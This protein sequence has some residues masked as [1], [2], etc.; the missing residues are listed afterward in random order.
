[1]D[2]EV[3]IMGSDANA[4][5]MARCCHEAYHKKA[6]L[7]GAYYRA[8]T[9]YSNILTIE[10]DPEIWSEEGFL[11]AL[12]NFRS[13]YPKSKILLIASNETYAEFIS[14]NRDTLKKDF[15]FNYPSIDI[16]KSLTTKEIFYKTYE[17]SILDFPK[18]KYYD[19]SSEDTLD[20]DFTY[21][22]IVK[23]SNVVS[24][25]HI[26][27]EGKNKIYKVEDK[28]ELKDIVDRIKMGGYQDT[29]IIQEFIPGDDSHLFDAVVYADRNKKVK[30]VSFAQIGLQ[31]H[32]KRMVGN[33]AVLMNGYNTFDGN[34]EEMVENI[35]TF[36]ENIGYMGFAEFDMKY[37]ERDHKFKVLEI[38]ARQGRCSYYISAAGFN[39]VSTMVDDLILEREIPYHVIQEPVLLSFVPKK[40]AKD[41]IKNEQLK[42]DVLKKWHQHV[43]PMKYKKD[44]NLRRKV[45]LWK[46]NK[47]YV[48]E[49][50]NGYWK[51]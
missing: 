34:V 37:D 12:K 46:M 27:F 26:D 22:I 6:H 14:K 17:N 49:Y 8:F 51:D 36:M 10:Y 19:C 39:L 48:E 45:L 35:K 42:K 3:L 25:N 4:Y 47:R 32:A 50:K 29:L 9:K 20:I 5:Y 23:P 2:F 41:Y 1:M 18:T 31:E 13:R 24:Y 7:I 33:A 43:N 16:I 44:K 15:Y 38:N 40:V 11:K 21:P 30:L 28:H